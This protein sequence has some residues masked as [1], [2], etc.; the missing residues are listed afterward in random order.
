LTDDEVGDMERAK[1]LLLERSK[2]PLLIIIVGIEE[3]PFM[4]M[5]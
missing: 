3:G 2:L 1:D 5:M 4:G